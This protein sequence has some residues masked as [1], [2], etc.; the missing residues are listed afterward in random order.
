MGYPW[1]QGDALLAND[2]NAAIANSIGLSSGTLPLNGSVPM[3][4]PL[5]LS[6]NAT[7][8][9]QAVPL[10]QLTTALASAPYVPVAGGVMAGTLT[11]AGNA[12]GVLDAVPLQQLNASITAAPYLPLATGGTVAG[13]VTIGTLTGTP[14][15]AASLTASG[16]MW[17]GAATARFGT[18]G[19]QTWVSQG[20]PNL[21]Y[22]DRLAQFQCNSSAGDAY[23]MAGVFAVRSSDAV[24][25]SSPTMGGIAGTFYAYNDAGATSPL[26]QNWAVYING[27]R[28]A[29]S[30]SVLGIEF[31]VSNMGDAQVVNSYNIS[32]GG[33]TASL[34]LAGGGDLA[35]GTSNPISAQIVMLN[36]GVTPAAAEKGIVA[37]NGA[38]RMN[39]TG[40]GGTAGTVLQMAR[41]HQI[42]WI[43]DGSGHVGS[44][45]R[46]NSNNAAGPNASVLFDNAHGFSVVDTA[47][48]TARFQVDTSTSIAIFGD[49]ATNNTIVVH[50]GATTGTT[51][52]ISS[53]AG[54]QLAAPSLTV[55]AP[56]LIGGASGPRIVTG[57]GAPSL[58]GIALGSLYIRSDGA[59]GTR[60]YVYQGSGVWNPIAGV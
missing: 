43:Y 45:I 49:P 50:P 13:T 56:L 48:E 37:T 58:T 11:L 12:V 33:V 2:L 59:A 31:E 36:N 35:A 17:V 8:P 1:T 28:N 57:A 3:T 55:P 6:G 53:P 51:A 10:Q 42:E 34:W 4:G 5:T 39:T 47:A 27:R 40:A 60:I 30:G 15:P 46:S 38:V 22:F 9:L 21:Y 25:P 32:A 24:T 14:P 26:K 19:F 18:G 54:L 44:F 41:N 29:G 23:S 20:N 7:Q 52:L 16:K